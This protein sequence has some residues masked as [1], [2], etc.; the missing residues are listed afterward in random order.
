MS[1]LESTQSEVKSGC[2]PKACLKT[3]DEKMKYLDSLS[4]GIYR[5]LLKQGKSNKWRKDTEMLQ[6]TEYKG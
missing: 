3:E 2:E 4:G 5:V 1:A 6:E